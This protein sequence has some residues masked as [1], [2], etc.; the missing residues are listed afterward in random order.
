VVI[1][2]DSQAPA[3]Q[4]LVRIDPAGHAE[5][6][7]AERAELGFP[8][9]VVMAELTG[10]APAVAA[11]L[12][13]ARLP[14]DVQTLGPI[15]LPPPSAGPPGPSRAGAGSTRSAG[16]PGAAAGPPSSADAPQVQVLL[17]A[18][19]PE[20]ARLAAGLHAAAALRSARREPGAVR[21][22]LDPPN[23]G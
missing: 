21:I 15:E 9:A 17:R 6:E 14:D 12:G 10:P 13:L 3:V 18:P 5:R 1:C 4:A 16:R 19:R 23:P 20:L 2:A 8:P 11:L 7:L 22:Q